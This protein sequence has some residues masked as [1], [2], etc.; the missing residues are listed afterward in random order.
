MDHQPSLDEHMVNLALVNLSSNT[1][2][3]FP[4]PW[5]VLLS[6]ILL[7]NEN[8]LP[9]DDTSSSLNSFPYLNVPLSAGPNSRSLTWAYR[10]WSSDCTCWPR[11]PLFH[12]SPS[13][14]EQHALYLRP[15]SSFSCWNSLRPLVQISYTHPT[16]SASLSFCRQ[17]SYLSVSTYKCDIPNWVWPSRCTNSAKNKLFISL[18]LD[19]ILLHLM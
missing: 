11:Y 12:L 13:R 18:I 3:F 19:I 5:D 4:N 17:F 8:S 10:S 15:C 1:W 14:F 2:A 16:S 6:W 7:V 9:P